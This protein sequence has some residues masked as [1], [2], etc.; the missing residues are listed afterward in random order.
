MTNL[1]DAVLTVYSKPDCENCE[2]TKTLLDDLKVPYTVEDLSLNPAALA[3]VKSLGF[4]AAPVV[5]PADG[6]KGWS[7]H[8][9]ERLREYA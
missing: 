7:G 2:K 4:R 9:E 3:H 5:I 1:T 8:K 6:T